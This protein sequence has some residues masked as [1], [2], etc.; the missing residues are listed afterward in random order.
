L[1]VVSSSSPQPG[2][3][4]TSRSRLRSCGALVTCDSMRRMAGERSFGQKMVLCC[5]K[6][7]GCPVIS[8][9][10]GGYVLSDA[11]QIN[12]GRVRMTREQAEILLRY[13][14]DRLS[15]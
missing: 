5:G 8:E 3:A 15:R 6:R 14:Q 1:L 12:P 13:L 9:E 2:D 7:R 4:P 10:K 11:E